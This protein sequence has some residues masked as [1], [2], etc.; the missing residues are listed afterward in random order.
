MLLAQYTPTVVIP[1]HIF[2]MTYTTG[3]VLYIM[4]VAAAAVGLTLISIAIGQKVIRWFS[5]SKVGGGA[6]ATMKRYHR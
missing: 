2:N 4:S 5:D 1:V 6:N 3:F